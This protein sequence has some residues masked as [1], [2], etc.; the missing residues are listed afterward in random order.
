MDLFGGLEPLFPRSLHTPRLS[1]RSFSLQ[2][3]IL[4]HRCCCHCLCLCQ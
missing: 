2:M 1:I 3:R 4:Q